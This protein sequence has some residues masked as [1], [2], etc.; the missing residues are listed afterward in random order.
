MAKAKLKRK[1]VRKH[2]R[3]VEHKRSE[4]LLFL[5]VI[6]VVILTVYGVSQILSGAVTQANAVQY[7]VVMNLALIFIGLISLMFFNRIHESII[8]LEEKLD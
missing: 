5:G 4:N 1:S 2:S 3:E 8:V 7:D 6:G